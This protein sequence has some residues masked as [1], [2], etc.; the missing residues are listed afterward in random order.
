MELQNGSSLVRLRLEEV[1]SRHTEATST[2]L[3]G[4]HIRILPVEP[5]IQ[6]GPQCG[7][8][9]LSMA[10]KYLGLERKEISEIL[11]CARKLGFT[12]QGEMF[13]AEW[14]RQLASSM[15]PVRATVISIPEASKLLKL[16]DS[17]KAVLIA[18]DCA[19][20]FEPALRNGH[21]AHWAL[22]AGYAYVDVNSEDIRPA[23]DVVVKDEDAVY[24]FVYHGKSKHMGLWSYP[25]LRQSS[26][27]LFEAG[28]ERKA[29]SY[30]LPHDGLDQLRGKCVLLE[31][32]VSGT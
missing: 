1:L 14:L 9:A 25:S 18:Y 20:N 30:V 6:N 22:L 12:N 3:P 10:T 15:W 29:P 5:L 32:D 31:K 13:S 11:E 23:T 28:P 21:G 16:I 2:S 8:V 19:K 7:L 4:A 26:L 24:V 27:N 17:G